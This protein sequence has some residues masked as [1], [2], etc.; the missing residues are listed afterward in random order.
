MM[1]GFAIT[2]INPD[3]MLLTAQMRRH[4]TTVINLVTLLVIVLMNL[5]AISATYQD[6]LL[7]NA[8]SPAWHQKQETLFVT[9]YAGF[10]VSQGISAATVYLLSYATT[11]VDGVT[12]PMN[13]LLLQ[14]LTVDIVNIDQ[15]KDKIES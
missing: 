7:G 3:I 12:K 10:V 1:Q 13:A 2:A 11:V 6:M 14:C 15:P 5:F 4:A 8:P 9:L